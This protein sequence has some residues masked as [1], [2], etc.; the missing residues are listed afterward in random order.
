MSNIYTNLNPWE[1]WIDRG[2]TFTDIVAK[3]P[4][5]Q[6]VIHKVLSENPD[7][8]SDAPCQGIREILGIPTDEPIPGE[9]I[10]A[11]KMGTTV[12]TNALLERKGDRT[13]LVI[14]QGFRDA[15]R[16]GYQNRPDIFAREIVLPEMLYEQAIEVAER[17]NAHGEELQPVNEAPL[18][19]QLQQAYNSGIRSC[20]IALM[21]GYRYPKHEQQIAEIA[22]KI[23]FTQISV[24]HQVSPLMKLV[25][26]GD[27][28]VVDAY[29]SPILR[30][31]V[32]RVAG[33]LSDNQSQQSAPTLM[34]M[35]SNGGLTDAQKFQGKDSI[36]SGPAGGIVG[37]VQT[38]KMAGFDKIITFDM[39]GTSTD[40]AHYNGEYERE[41]ETEIAGVRLRTPMMSI[42][43]VAAGG[44]SILFFDGSRYRVGP[45]SAG[46]NPGPACYRQNGPLTV[47]DCNVMLGKIQP[48]FF[49]KVFGKNG[50]LPLD[51]EIVRQKFHQLTTE[52]NAKTGSNS[53]PEQVAAGFLA[54]AVENMA[55][56][57]KKISLQRG[58]DVSEYTLCCFGG[59]GGQHAC[60]IAETLGMK[61]V[62]I[63]PYAGVLSAFGMGLADVRV[64]QQR[65][66]EAPLSPELLSKL[67]QI[68]TE[69][70]AKGKQEIANKD[71]SDLT[72]NQDCQ[73][74]PKVQLK[75]QGT[76]SSLIVDFTENVATMQAEFA[77]A[78]QQRYGFI[79]PEKALIVEAVS[80]EV[81]QIMDSPEDPIIY[82]HS[83]E[84]PSPIATVQMYVGD[85]WQETP[86]FQRDMLQ[87]GDIITGPGI[88]IEATGT[89]AI[90][91]NWQAKITEKN[92]LILTKQTAISSSP[93]S[94]K[95]THITAKPDPVMLEI[96]NNLFRA[97]AE[98]MGITLQNTASSV[99][100][101]ERLDFSCAIFDQNGQLVAN[102]PH[103]P[104]HLGSMS[105][106]VQA[107]IKDKNNTL[108]PGDVYISN[109]P[110]NGGT[111]LPDITVITPVFISES[112]QKSAAPSGAAP[113][114]YL[115]SRGHHADIGGITPG[116]M[117]PNSTS[118][119]Q[120][121]ILFDNFQ[122]VF[123]G[124]FQENELLEKLNSSPY[125]ARNPAQNIAD[126]QAQ[127][128]AN[129]RG[130]QEIENMVNHFGL[131]TVQA[132]MGYVQNN[133]EE[134]VRRVINVLKDG[135][136]TYLMDAGGTIQVKVTLDKTNRSAKIDF[137]GT[138][139]QQNSNFNAPAAVCK[140]AVLYV[141]RTLVDDNIPLN[142]GCMKPLEIII[143][144]GCMLNPQY[145]A[146]V[147]AGNVETSQ[148]IVDALYGAL[149]VMAASQ[150]TMNNFTFGN[151]KYQ[152]YETIC[153]GSGAGQTFN[154][155]DAVHTHMTNS[156][157]TDPEV[158]EWRFPVIL[159][160]FAIRENSGGKGQYR[161]GNG[162][163]RCLRF[164]E[165]MTAGIL[166]NHRLISPFGLNGG[167]D[168]A[169]G[170]NYVQRRDGT[171]EQLDSTGA[172]EMYPGD[173]F[174]IETPGGGG[175]GHDLIE[176]S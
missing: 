45:E 123:R 145:P 101:K 13:V 33:Q 104:V 116:S 100:I 67:Q 135:E 80:V 37:A 27:T 120:E 102:A 160:S 82:R 99:N 149:G 60:Q 17:Y 36:L 125:A 176:E 92:H 32:D 151:E 113:I 31:Y 81:V 70:A 141:F 139:P 157:L 43:T 105:E 107:L 155:T 72:E 170:K 14:T 69:L 93:V 35:Q 49:P 130:I 71:I 46:A 164:Q 166:S 91:P 136:F 165:Q 66:I 30:R 61:Q 85:R 168:G 42:N 54:I 6:L 147:V 154:G 87:P 126:L 138:S 74:F 19:A 63:H 16:I 134:S 62:F 140:A 94:P 22:R 114:F 12:A 127:I 64:I 39:G 59:A 161:G 86:V 26:R 55:N 124:K 47:T 57:I 21:H 175:Y 53:T 78:H 173:M 8:Y 110:Y 51:G 15:L 20:A 122:L 34:F 5:G 111:H 2:G 169:L 158:L 3:R 132:Y 73:V 143:P 48:Q 18:I 28:T 83:P 133:A 106:S 171:V 41:F 112:S 68:F 29:L 40:V 117:P 89:N 98:Q 148:A 156:R 11:V 75:Y 146:A 25:S 58:Y 7:R 131:E 56:A 115:A 77:A 90:A 137:T 38:S 129:K 150:G 172:V 153:G 108:Q 65:A 76:D 52:I 142:A 159:E 144:E 79:Q 95:T 50:D 162:V 23:G 1:F 88:I 174:I 128:A 118:V 103:I 121:G 4:D 167:S 96:F 97:I 44:G 163:I 109:N 84:P 10:S 24:S 9:L 119:E 152:Y